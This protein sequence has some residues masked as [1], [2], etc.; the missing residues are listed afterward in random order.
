MTTSR[1]PGFSSWAAWGSISCSA[2]SSPFTAMRSAWKSMAST[3]FSRPGAKNPRTA[4][5]RSP[6]VSMGF[7]PR[8][9][10]IAAAMRPAC[11]SSPYSDSIRAS[12]GASMSRS[13]SRAVPLC[14]R[15]IRRSSSP[16]RRMEKP[17]SATSNWCDDTPRSASTP[18]TARTPCSRRKPFKCLK[19]SCMKVNRGSSGTLASASPSWSK[20]NSRPP[21]P[22]RASMAREWPPPPKVAST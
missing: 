16:S 15:S 12:S 14:L 8:A 21:S 20:P 1:P 19:F 6:V 3:R 18:S 13:R 17:R 5:F 22:K 11:G 2:S 10:T 7:S 9:F 4:S